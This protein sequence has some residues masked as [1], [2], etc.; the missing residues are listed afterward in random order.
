MENPFK[1]YRALNALNMPLVDLELATIVDPNKDMTDENEAQAS[2]LAIIKNPETI[3]IDPIFFSQ[4]S[5]GVFGMKP[6]FEDFEFL[7]S[8]ITNA[9]LVLLKEIYKDQKLPIK[10]FSDDVANYI[11]TCCLDEG[12]FFLENELKQ[13]QK[14]LLD[15]SITVNNHKIPNS[16]IKKCQE[17]WN[18]VKDKE[19]SSISNVDYIDEQIIINIINKHYALILSKV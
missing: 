16:D 18:L 5:L 1:I 12:I 9:V 7:S 13:F 8:E 14:N 10:D 2:I 6:S 11:A 19:I 3:F 17:K 4:I 15:I